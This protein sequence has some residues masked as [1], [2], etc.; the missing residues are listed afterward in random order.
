MKTCKQCNTE[1]PITEYYK[2]GPNRYKNVCKECGRI[3]ALNRYHSLTDDQKDKRRKLN[4]NSDW[5]KEYKLMKNYGIT[6]KQFDEMH[7]NQNGKC[8]ICEKII[9]GRDIK[10]DHNH[11]TGKVRKLLC[12]HCNTSLGLLNENP[13]LFYKCINYLKEFDDNI[14]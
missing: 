14:S 4:Y 3:K 12:H 10:V 7:Q 9:E 2:N 13:E 1:K 11:K 5:H 8:Y 6:R